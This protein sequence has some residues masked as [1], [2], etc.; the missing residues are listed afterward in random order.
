MEVE[1]LKGKVRA[2]DF[3]GNIYNIEGIEIIREDKTKVHYPTDHKFY[4]A[5]AAVGTKSECKKLDNN[6]IMLL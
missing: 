3:I 4:L 1:I 2:K 5:V 6:S